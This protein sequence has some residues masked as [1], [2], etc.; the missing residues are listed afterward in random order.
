MRTEMECQENAPE[1]FLLH[2]LRR[3]ISFFGGRE[4]K[5]IERELREVFRGDVREKQRLSTPVTAVQG[6]V[7]VRG[8]PFHT[9]LLILT[10][11]GCKLSD[12]H[13]K[14]QKSCTIVILQ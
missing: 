8:K 11:G 4:S 14:T 12:L 13:V 7:G 1:R 9:S 2:T 6:W 5:Q 10:T 3:I